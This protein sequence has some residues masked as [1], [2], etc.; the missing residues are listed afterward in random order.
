[1]PPTELTGGYRVLSYLDPSELSHDKLKQLLFFLL[2]SRR[3]HVIPDFHS[4]YAE[5]FEGLE[6]ELATKGKAAFRDAS[7]QAAFNFLACALYDT[8]PTETK[9]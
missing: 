1:M 7:D 8:N 3:N 6:N 4:S 9:L 2:K 5:L